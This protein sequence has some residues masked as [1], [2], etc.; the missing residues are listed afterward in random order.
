M[1]RGT[2]QRPALFQLYVSYP[3]A[4]G[5]QTRTAQGSNNSVRCFLIGAEC[6]VNDTQREKDSPWRNNEYMYWLGVG[7]VDLAKGK[8]SVES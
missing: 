5:R 7:R 3:K 4:Q 1:L 8:K 6:R 2:T